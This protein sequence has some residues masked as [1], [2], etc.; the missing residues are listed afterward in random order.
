MRGCIPRS[1]FDEYIQEL[2]ETS[3]V[4]EQEHN[5]LRF[6]IWSIVNT[7]LQDVIG[8]SNLDKL[9]SEHNS[10]FVF[11]RITNA[12]RRLKR[13]VGKGQEF[14]KDIIDHPNNIQLTIA[15]HELME[16]VK[17]E[18]DKARNNGIE[19]SKLISGEFLPSVPMARVVASIGR[20]IAFQKGIRFTRK[21]DSK[22]SFARSAADIE[23]LYYGLGR[24]AVEELESLG[25][26][27]I[28]EDATIIQDFVRIDDLRDAGKPLTVKEVRGPGIS[29]VEKKL[30]IGQEGS[31]IPVHK[32]ESV[33]YF[34]NRTAANLDQTELGA[35][36]DMLR[37]ARQLTQPSSVVL[38]DTRF[39]RTPEDLRKKDVVTLDPEMDEARLALYN[40]PLYVNNAV[41]EML[42]LL[43]QMVAEDGRSA[44]A[45]L[46][47]RLGVEEG[48]VQSLLGL[49]VSDD[50]SID[51]KESIGGQNLSKTT[52]LD[53]LG[54]YYDVILNEDGSRLPLR[55]AMW[56]GRNA[57]LYYEN[58][59]LN[60]HASK[61][62]RYM[63]SPGEYSVDAVG[64]DF[65]F[66]VYGIHQALGKQFSYRE[67][68]QGGNKNLEAALKLYER[69]TAAD[70]IT[71]KM[72]HLRR[73][74]NVL[75]GVDYVSI[76]TGLQAVQDIR[77]PK[78]GKVTTEFAVASDA[79]ASGG[80]MTFSQAVGTKEDVTRFMEQIGLFEQADLS[81]EEKLD[82]LY[83]LMSKAIEAYVDDDVNS[84]DSVDTLND[85]LEL[86]FDRR[87]DIRDL[88]KDPTM[89]FVYGQGKRSAMMTMSRAL[90]DRILNNLDAPFVRK[91]IKRFPKIAKFIKAETGQ[92]ISSA[93][94]ASM[95][96][97]QG[98]YN[99]I[100][101]ELNK[102]DGLSAT[103]YKIMR[104]TIHEGYLE[105]YKD[106]GDKLWALVSQ[107]P[108]TTRMKVLPASAVLNGRKNI[109]KYGMPITKMFE[110]ATTTRTFPNEDVLTRKEKLTR[111]VM[112]VSTI[113]GIDAA[114]LYNSIIRLFKLRRS[115]MKGLVVVHDEVRGTV[116]NIRRLEQLFVDV[117]KE[118][119]MAYDVHQQVLESI[120]HYAP[121]VAKT[122][123]FKALEAR[124]DKEVTAKAE[125]IAKRFNKNTNALIGDGSAFL[126]FKKLSEGET[127]TV[128]LT[129]KQEQ[130]LEAKF[131]E[132]LDAEMVEQKRSELEDLLKN[133]PEDIFIYDL[134]T[135]GTTPGKDVIVQAAWKKGN[136]KTV[137]RQ[138]QMTGDEA[139]T[140]LYNMRN[141]ESIRNS[142]IYE[143]I[144]NAYFK[145]PTM[146]KWNE[147]A[148]SFAELKR[149]MGL[150]A[151]GMK[152]VISFNG[153]N[154]DDKFLDNKIKTTHDLRRLVQGTV[155]NT[156]AE[157]KLTD[158]VDVGNTTAH[159]ADSDVELTRVLA[160]RFVAGKAKMRTLGKNDTDEESSSSVDKQQT[161]E[162]LMEEFAQ[163]S[164]LIRTFLDRKGKFFAFSNSEYDFNADEIRINIDT[165]Q[166]VIAG[167]KSKP[168]KLDLKNPKH[169]QNLK[170]TIEHEVTHYFTLAYLMLTREG[171]DSGISLPH[172][173]VEDQKEFIRV[174]EKL[175]SLYEKDPESL[176]KRVGTETFGRIEYIVNTYMFGEILG[177]AEFVAVMN[178]EPN[179]AAKIYKELNNK[180]ALRLMERVREFIKRI[181]EWLGAKSAKE[182]NEE[183]DIARIQNGINFTVKAGT[184]LVNKEVPGLKEKVYKSMPFYLVGGTGRSP[185]LNRVTPY[186]EPHKDRELSV[187]Y[188][189]YAVASILTSR[190][191]SKA[192]RAGASIHHFMMDKFPVYSDAAGLIRGVYDSNEDLQGL[193]HMITG[194][195]INKYKKADILSQFAKVFRHRAETITVETK[196]FNAAMQ[197]MTEEEKNTVGRFVMETPLHDYFLLS[198]EHKTEKRIQKRINKLTKELGGPNGSIVKDVDSIIEWRVGR[199]GKDEEFKLP[200][201]KIFNLDAKYNLNDSKNGEKVRELLVLK[202]IDKIGGR[203]FEKLLENTELVDLL[204]DHTVA[205]RL[206]TLQNDGMY[207]IRD[208]LIHD[209]YNETTQHRV[210]TVEDVPGIMAGEEKGWKI[211]RHPTK[212]MPGIAYRQIIDS[213]EQPGVFTDLKLLS[214]DLSVPERMKDM[215]G[216]VKSRN[217]YKLI[218]TY[219][220]KQLMGVNNDFVQ[221][222]VRS[223]AHNIAIVESQAIRDALL[224]KDVRMEITKATEGRLVDIIESTN[225]DNP[226]FVKL[227]DPKDFETMHPRIRAKYKLVGLRVSDVQGFGDQVTLVRKDIA[228]WLMGGQAKGLFENTQYQWAH[229]IVKNL[230][231]TSKIGMVVL[232]PIKIAM[233]MIANISYLSMSGAGPIF[234]TKNM[235]DINK[236]FSKYQEY[237]RQIVQMKIKLAANPESE[238]LKKRLKTL[239]DA[240]KNTS[241]GDL[242]S[243]GF[244]N[245][246]GSELVS[247]SGDSLAGL[248]ADTHR[249]LTYL[250]KTKDGKD[251]ITSRFIERLQNLGFNGEDFLRYI[252]GIASR[253]ESG[254]GMAKQLDEVHE[255]LKTIRSERDVIN[256]VMQYTTSPGSEAVRLGA[257]MTDLVD[258]MA[259][260][261]LYRHL[262][263]NE[264]MSAEDAKI[265]VLD[266]FP[267]Y[268]QNAPMAIRQLSDNGI[269]MF[270]SYWIP[271]QRAL[272][273][274]VRDKPVNVGI[275]TVLE[276]AMG[277]NLG[278][279]FDAALW[280]K[281]MGYGVFNL[282]GASVGWG[283]LFPTRL[284]A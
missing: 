157:G 254:Q 204:K 220:E 73:M 177:V 79:T 31:K 54:D 208:S 51:K 243:K 96:D 35:I 3:L 278:T 237:Q 235:F 231:A 106:R 194:E 273:R 148:I 167:D 58:T 185:I 200:K 80:T 6:D 129:P 85:T 258:V 101:E 233:D 128:E 140:Y 1:L 260:E 207:Q 227:G 264:G 186:I 29:L 108:S 103:L 150:A 269:L 4:N 160:D 199:K 33:K 113:H 83:H 25:Y 48:A 244:I 151:E 67:L 70:T 240:A 173:A 130:K 236:E 146:A 238:A 217:G 118:V 13:A 43:N 104:E 123:E 190:I 275:E 40:T 158:F 15:L 155:Q 266:S 202:S 229:R 267:D 46:T 256:Y 143:K 131:E 76:L 132:E 184:N 259:K 87:K 195:G 176:K 152:A 124:I 30:H 88:S 98:L 117:T 77:N 74:P 223:S 172:R 45:L 162:K 232:N 205:N 18:A 174:I 203:K 105:N 252:G 225:R 89:T 10:R 168:I 248:E 255:R 2:D 247:R 261:T 102:S 212:G 214:S 81:T 114:Q 221:A 191:E 144:H 230:I 115:A 62:S 253:Y 17:G 246:L 94:V 16:S 11:T 183:F 198:K 72:Q 213:T 197:G 188:L 84:E 171:V 126:D 216:V 65:D 68:T 153:L 272:W 156:Y 37:I 24:L 44:S 268:K 192:Q 189:N 127:E 282:P 99:K 263:E 38:P 239:Q 139:F 159:S 56:S 21:D 274:L 170:E 12:L 209:Y 257:A 50:Y 20:K 142:K 241:V 60:A 57:R 215:R 270:P 66:L 147:D 5:D 32:R 222:L 121:H 49:K 276:E 182:I 210:I 63:L 175:K 14:K 22:K 251:N 234:I 138:L 284:M 165:D 61:Q 242:D 92:K 93:S 34:L 39:E 281:L 280:N 219:E 283:S 36:T 187:S 120:K 250:L 136:G 109:D 226:W 86:L 42:R 71:A 249:A 224:E 164:P 180:E 100:V 41:H 161:L 145:D 26:V 193:M 116:K 52:P 137:T 163:T 134:E 245:S 279:V 206:S 95:N 23:E 277:A 141:V 169:L 271:I 122:A 181:A 112:D 19:L 196:K 53:D 107:I 265:R 78:D 69:F 55:M 97:V 27:K 59:L 82:D 154:F 178:G 7:D 201:G 90:A 28:H 75:P 91:Y 135:S 228:H 47:T 64:E 262:M 179:N 125:L 9:K 8:K 111:S 133:S 211:A 149:E 119:L 218:P 110:L 166:G